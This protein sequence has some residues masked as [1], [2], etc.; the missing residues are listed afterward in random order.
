MVGANS[1]I[2][3]VISA[4]KG[5]F[6]RRVM[7]IKQINEYNMCQIEYLHLRCACHASARFENNIFV[8]N[9]I[10]TR[11]YQ[12]VNLSLNDN[13]GLGAKKKVLHIQLHKS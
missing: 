7:L 1:L 8:E 13:D 4:R 12:F 6:G 10:H 9:A 2:L 3:N 5:I 11:V